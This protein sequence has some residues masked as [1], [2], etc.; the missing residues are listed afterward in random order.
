MVKRSTRKYNRRYS[1]GGWAFTGQTIP[2][3]SNYGQVNTPIGD[4]RAQ[5]P[6]GYISSYSS[7][8]LPGLSGGGYNEN[9]INGTGALAN[10]ADD[11]ELVV[12]EE[13]VA[14]QSG[15]RYS[16]DLAEPLPGSAA[17]WAG[18]I[19]TVQRIPCEGAVH[20]PLNKQ[21][22]G[23]SLRNVYGIKKRF[24]R[25]LK[26]LKKFT[27]SLA[28]LK[29]LTKSLKKRFTGKGGKFSMRNVYKLRNSLTKKLRNGYKGAKKFGKGLKKRF[30]GKGGK[31]SMR[32]VYN[33]RNS[34]TKKLRNGYKGAKK[35]GKGL[36]KRFTG[37]GGGLGTDSAAYYAPTAG[38]DNK[39][40]SWLNSVGAPVQLQIP[41]EARSWNPACLTTN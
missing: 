21:M 7:K 32:N 17:P 9:E 33:L 6:P 13:L 39:P 30:T 27:P 40:S 38:Y 12:N 11:E 36:K 31:F 22:G 34:L 25:N 29:K 41:Y 1:G 19:P 24:S 8:G 28:G 14:N 20:N 15:G 2:G 35:F 18:G 37:R 4:C 26:G 16:F 3:V 23:F 5:Q 10:T